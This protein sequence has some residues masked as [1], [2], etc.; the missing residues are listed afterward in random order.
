M[1][2]N[3]RTPFHEGV[4]FWLKNMTIEASL[5]LEIVTLGEG[6]CAPVSNIE[7]VWTKPS[8]V[9]GIKPSPL[10]EKKIQSFIEEY[11]D[12]ASAIGGPVEFRRSELAFT[13]LP[14]NYFAL[15]LGEATDIS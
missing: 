7:H 4:F 12:V 11:Q 8:K 6:L 13:A 3:T 10:S 5:Q 2:A 14:D 15:K 1:C 9:P